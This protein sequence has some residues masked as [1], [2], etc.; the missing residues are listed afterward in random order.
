MPRSGVNLKMKTFLALL[1]LE[2]SL[3]GAAED[4]AGW[5]KA[6]WGMTIEEVKAAMPEIK[7]LRGPVAGRTVTRRE[8][9]EWG[10]DSVAIGDAAWSVL[11]LFDPEKHLYKVA[12]RPASS[13]DVSPTLFMATEGLLR[14]KYGTAFEKSDSF[15]GEH[16]RYSLWTLPQTRI[17]L[18]FS[19]RARPVP[20]HSLWLEYSQPRDADHF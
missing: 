15:E 2:V 7:P 20:A 4:P 16:T 9:A 5:N 18:R 6:R 13:V 12:L 8:I 11:F 1:V 10:I 14:R 17:A 19:S 3:A